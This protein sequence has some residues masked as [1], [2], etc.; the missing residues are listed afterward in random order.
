[1]AYWTG[2]VGPLTSGSQTFTTGLTGAPIGCRIIV[3]GK[4]SDTAN[5]GS[6]GTYDGTRQNVQYWSNTSSGTNN[7]SVILIKDASG[8]VIL[9]AAA[10]A[11]GTSGGSGTVTLN[12]TTLDTGFQ[13]TIEVWN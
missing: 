8:T 4:S 2:R 3:G 12:C 7:T 1:M 13:P 5:H 11:L 9:Q 6:I 10:T